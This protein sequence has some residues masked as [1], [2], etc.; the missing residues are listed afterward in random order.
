M[1][2]YAIALAEFE[3][4]KY[5]KRNVSVR[6]VMKGFDLDPFTWEDNHGLNLAGGTTCARRLTH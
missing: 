5:Q 4:A 2:T 3:L 6:S 1:I